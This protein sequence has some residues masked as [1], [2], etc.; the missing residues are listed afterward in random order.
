MVKVAI[1][2]FGV[3]GSGV[4]EVLSGNGAGIQ[5]KA[6][7][8][9]EVKYILDVRDFHDSPFAQHFVKDFS[10]IEHDPEVNVVV[11][12][13]GGVGAA[14]DFTERALKQGKSVVTSNKELVATH[15]RRLL[16]LAAQNNAVYLFEASVGGG[17]PIIQPMHQCLAA[18]RIREVVGI[19]NG[20][21]NFILTRMI[22]EQ[23]GFD[24]AL[25]MA[26]ELGYAERNPAADVEGIDTCRKICI[27]ASL[28][29]GRQ[30][31]PKTVYTEG[32]T[33]LTLADAAYAEHSDRAVKLIGRAKQLEDGNLTTMVFPVFLPKSSQLSGIDD[34]FNGIL[35]RGDATGDVMFYG[36][37]AGKFPTASA[38]AADL[39][40]AVKASGTSCSLTWEETPK[41][42]IKDWRVVPFSFYLRIRTTDPQAVLS[43][44]RNQMPELKILSRSGQPEDEVAVETSPM[45]ERRLEEIWSG[46]SGSENQLL[47]KIRILDD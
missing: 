28:A 20:T 32:I 4:A 11:E 40:E 18:N 21:T 9:I 14:L 44:L 2:G 46:L 27:L 45:S 37:G 3:V 17:I 34:V 31:D 39:I 42:Q 23:M 38:V 22:R 15:G 36:K 47:G 19:L 24:E 35:V 5:K 29:F 8:L 25:K 10:V 7:E 41:A 12:T 6:D 1:L 26:Q 16:D 13:I 30:V 33:K 43:K